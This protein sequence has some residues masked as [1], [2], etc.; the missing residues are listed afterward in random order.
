MIGM[1]RKVQCWTH[2]LVRSSGA[3][4]VLSD[5]AYANKLDSAQRA[6]AWNTTLKKSQSTHH[7]PPQKIAGVHVKCQLTKVPSIMFAGPCAVPFLKGRVRHLSDVY[8]RRVSCREPSEPRLYD[9]QVSLTQTDQKKTVPD[10][11]V[12]PSRRHCRP[13]LRIVVA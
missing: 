4:L 1:R 8:I 10:H 6:S 5:A 12:D 2:I 9:R 13:S 7:K 3:S 11:W